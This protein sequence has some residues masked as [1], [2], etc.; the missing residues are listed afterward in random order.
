M[1]KKTM[2]RRGRTARKRRARRRTRRMTKKTKK[3]KRKTARKT[4][5]VSPHTFAWVENRSGNLL[6]EA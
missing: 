3:T 2:R 6:G 1:T 5:A 4:E